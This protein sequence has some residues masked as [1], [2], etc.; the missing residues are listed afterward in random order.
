MTIL[1]FVLRL[2]A[3]IFAGALVGLER[4]RSNKSAGIRTNTLVAMGACIYVLINVS[5][6]D[7]SGTDPT[8]II[9][10][11]VTGIGFLGAGVILH[12]GGSI[13]GLTTAATVW[14]SAALGC[15]AGLGMYWEVLICTFAVFMINVSFKTDKIFSRSQ[16]RESR[17]QKRDADEE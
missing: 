14:C 15:L 7:H 8:R 16:E 4:Q 12:H 6:S 11:I 2:L 3:S 1:S 5:L 17:K 10:Q 13:Q 9:G